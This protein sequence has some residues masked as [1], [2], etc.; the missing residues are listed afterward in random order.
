M[1]ELI[2][3]LRYLINKRKIGK[4]P[5][6]GNLQEDGSEDTDMERIETKFNE[7]LQKYTKMYKT[8]AAGA[9]QMSPED[10]KLVKQIF[11]KPITN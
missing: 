11:K 8:Y 10:E 7:Q 6:T 9:S 5:F 1:F 4:E 2:Q 3:G